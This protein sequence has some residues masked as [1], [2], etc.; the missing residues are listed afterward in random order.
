MTGTENDVQLA[1]AG[2]T[3]AFE[4][5]YRDHVARVHGLARR[6]IGPEEADDLTQ[7]VFV[8]VWEK[9]ETFRGDSAFGTWL[10]RVAVNFILTRARSRKRQGAWILDDVEALDLVGTEP[11]TQGTAIDLEAALGRLPEGARQVFVLHDV[12]G[13]RHN[14]IAEM[15]DLAVGTSKSQLHRARLLLRRHLAA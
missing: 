15:L 14:E 13:Y 3:R 12:E 6:M 9:L 11:V 8:R 5:L 10:H 2:D 7:E 1:V 4:R